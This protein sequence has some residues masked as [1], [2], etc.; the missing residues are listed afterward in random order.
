[1]DQYFEWY[2]MTEEHKF[3]FAKPKLVREARLHW[4]SVERTLSL[5]GHDPI[6]T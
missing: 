2:D 3:R 6:T 5:G 4:A 1:M